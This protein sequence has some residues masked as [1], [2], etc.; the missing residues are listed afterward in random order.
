M[1]DFRFGGEKNRTVALCEQVFF[2]HGYIKAYTIAESTFS[3]CLCHTAQTDS[4]SRTN[5]TLSV[6]LIEP[7]PQRVELLGVGHIVSKRFM[8]EQIDT[9]SSPLEFGRDGLTGIEGRNAESY[10]RGRH[11]D[12]LKRAAHRV[13]AADGWQAESQLHFE[14]AQQSRHGLAIGVRIGGHTL[15]VLLIGEAHAMIVST[16]CHHLGTSIHHGI[17]CAVIRTPRTQIRIEAVSHHRSRMGQSGSRQFLHRNLCLGQLRLTSKRHKH[18]RATDGSV[19]LFNQSFLRENIVVAQKVGHSLCQTCSMDGA[20]KGV[21][22][23]HSPNGS[24]GIVTC[25]GTINKSATQVCHTSVTIKKTHTSRVGHIRHMGNLYVV[26][27]TELFKDGL[28]FLFHHHCHTLLALADRQFGGIKSLILGLDAVKVDV[29]SVRQFADGY[30]HAA[31]TKVVGLLDEFRHFRTAEEALQ[32]PFFGGIAFLHLAAACMERLFGM[33]FGRACGTAYT[34]ASCSS[35]QQQDHIACLGTLTAHLVGRYSPYH[36]SH[37]HALGDIS[38]VIHFAHMGGSQSYLVAVG[39][40]ALCRLAG[41]DPLGQLAGHGLRNGLIDVART[42][43]AHRLIDVCTSGQRVTNGTTKARTRSSERLNL[44]GVIMGLVLELQ[45]PFLRF[46]ILIYVNKNGAGIV[47]FAHLH[48]VQLAYG[49]QITCANSR[50][51]HEA[52]RFFVAS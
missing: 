36:G 24:I 39:R 25:T 17:G 21:F 18:R 50:Q 52:Q 44:R 20:G 13:F 40:I 1:R 22:V 29:Q 19:K 10:E 49:A 46:A 32:F 9:L 51:L 43:Y 38:G 15:K 31:R 35:A 4:P 7:C 41:D 2:V 3:Q 42:G 11:I 28:V 5:D 47:L 14:C 27:S 26:C 37:L 16:G 12:V 34:V 33:F 30:T 8:T 23:C 45:Q 48:I 6:L